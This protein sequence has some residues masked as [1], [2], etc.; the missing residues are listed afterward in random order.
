V[1]GRGHTGVARTVEHY[2]MPFK[3][4][5]MGCESLHTGWA[6]VDFEDAVAGTTAEVVMMPFPGHFVS[7]R[8]AGK[9]HHREPALCYKRLERTIDGSN[10][11]T[12]GIRLSGQQHF[13][14][15]ERIIGFFKNLP[16]SLA[17][18][19]IAIHSTSSIQNPEVNNNPSRISW[20]GRVLA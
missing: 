16:N 19:S 2:L 18:A 9:R 4:E 8:F 15:S 17:L 5:A 13:L 3:T 10:P 6:P 11:Q 12:W 20:L 1:S 7:L 14:W